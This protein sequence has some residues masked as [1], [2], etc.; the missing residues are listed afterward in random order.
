MATGAPQPSAARLTWP[1]LRAREQDLPELPP[2]V[3]SGHERPL[4]GSEAQRARSKRRPALEKPDGRVW[5]VSR[6]T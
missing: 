4:P 1:W 6:R 2:Q 3:G 5:V